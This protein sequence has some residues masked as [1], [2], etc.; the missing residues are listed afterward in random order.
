MEI[1]PKEERKKASNGNTRTKNCCQTL[2]KKKGMQTPAHPP[3]T[4]SPIMLILPSD[5][6]SFLL[7]MSLTV[8]L[9]AVSGAIRA[10][11]SGHPLYI[12]SSPSDLY[13]FLRQSN[14]PL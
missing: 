12:F 4:I 1:K 9:I 7:Q 2:S 5:P 11:F 3:A 10:A 14:S 13:V 6:V 8:I